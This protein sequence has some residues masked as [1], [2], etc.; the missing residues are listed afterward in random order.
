MLSSLTKARDGY[1]VVS[2]SSEY[3]THSSFF[4]SLDSLLDLSCDKQK[5]LEVDVSS[6]TKLNI[7]GFGCRIGEITHNT[8][9]MYIVSDGQRYSSQA[10]SEAVADIIE[11]CFSDTKLTRR[12]CIDEASMVSEYDFRDIRM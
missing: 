4:V 3:S 6:N 9:Q 7:V 12:E 8:G 5:K 11:I 2:F 1:G 10:T